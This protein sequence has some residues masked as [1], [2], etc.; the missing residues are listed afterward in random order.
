MSP[1]VQAG[2]GP[3]RVVVLGG[4]GWLGRHLHSLARRR[5][6]DVLAV[7]RTPVSHIRGG[8][9]R[10]MDVAHAS[11]GQVAALLEEFR[12]DVVVNAV[13][14]A[15][16][17][18][19][20][21]RTE[22]EMAASNVHLV[23]T[24]LSA[25]AGLAHR[26]RLVHVSTVLEYGPQS[27]GTSLCAATPL[28]PR[29]VYD[30]TRLVGSLAVLR[31]ARAGRVDAT[32]VRLPNLCGPHPSPA[33][34]FGKLLAALR[35]SARSGRTV[36]V[37]VAKAHRDFVDVRDA[38]DGVLRAAVVPEAVG[39]AVNL[40]SGRA[41]EIRTLVRLFTRAAGLSEGA[42]RDTGQPVA[43]LGGDWIRVDV[44]EAWDLLGW[45]ARTPLEVSLRE[46]WEQDAA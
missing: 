2:E 46:A 6:H 12:A 24:L 35:E 19:G 43:S 38:A 36:R 31:A 3:R 16:A 8:E 27:P 32:V 5:G 9:F 39:R 33:T 20:W 13:D 23:D 26:P 29:T 34:F 22:E 45:R 11:R 37:A 30:R 15:N 25:V 28:T 17:T 42:V 40:G 44:E 41:V 18:D 7:A 1:T 10:R 21:E 4:T 14:S